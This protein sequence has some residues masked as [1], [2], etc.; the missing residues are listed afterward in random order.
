MSQLKK[1]NESD[2]IL[3]GDLIFSTSAIIYKENL[4]VFQNATKQINLSL[5]DVQHV[6]SSGL[7]LIVEWFRITKKNQQRLKIKNIPDQMLALA[8]L[9]SVDELLLS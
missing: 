9:S 6:D 8:K 1:I 5:E 3:S 4:S 7:A 2:F